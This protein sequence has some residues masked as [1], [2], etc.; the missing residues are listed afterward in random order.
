MQRDDLP[1][2]LP[3][4]LHESC[5]RTLSPARPEQ[6][7]S[8]ERAP[9]KTLEANRLSCER[10]NRNEIAANCNTRHRGDL[11]VGFAPDASDTPGQDFSATPSI[12]S[13]PTAT[14]G[15]LTSDR[16]R[17]ETRWSP[18]AFLSQTAVNAAS[19][20]DRPVAVRVRTLLKFCD[21]ERLAETAARFQ[22]IAVFAMRRRV[23]GGRHDQAVVVRALIFCRVLEHT[24]R[25]LLVVCIIAHPGG[26]QGDSLYQRRAV[27]NI[28]EIRL[29]PRRTL[30]PVKRA[31]RRLDAIE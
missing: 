12:I 21:I 22:R 3:R 6:G 9:L 19:R 28:V 16:S 23:I 7:V 31:Y 25:D 8:A 15:R 17:G 20:R 5:D 24:L 26:R 13:L 11:P 18:D 14:A 10:V 30:R 2:A 29:R 1:I 27:R 4:T